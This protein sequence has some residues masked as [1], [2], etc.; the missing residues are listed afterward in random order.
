MKFTIKKINIFVVFRLVIAVIFIA[1]G[2]EKLLS[3]VEN[4]VYAIQSYDLIHDPD[5]QESIALLFPW[6]E[7]FAGVFP[8]F[9]T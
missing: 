9:A 7:L 2:T 8:D 1:S 6:L 5:L 4:F 3:P